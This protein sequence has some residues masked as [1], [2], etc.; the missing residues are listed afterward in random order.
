MHRLQFTF[1]NFYA[2]V[3]CWKQGYQPA[4]LYVFAFIA[5]IIGGNLFGL[6][7]MLLAIPTAAILKRIFGDCI[8]TFRSSNFFVSTG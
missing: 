1:L 8:R 4:R 7:G 2:G 5:L 3:L 6:F